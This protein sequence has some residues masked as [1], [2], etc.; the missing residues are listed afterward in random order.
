MNRR[1]LEAAFLDDTGSGTDLDMGLESAAKV[2]LDIICADIADRTLA[3]RSFEM[4]AGS[5]VG[6][7]GLLCANRRF[8][9]VLQ[10]KIHPVRE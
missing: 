9:V 2:I 6:L 1:W 10:E 7:V 4:Q 5:L 3:K 8:G